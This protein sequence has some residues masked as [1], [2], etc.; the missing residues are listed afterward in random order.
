MLGQDCNG[1]QGAVP[2]PH[3]GTKGTCLGPRAS[4]GPAGSSDGVKRGGKSAKKE[5]LEEEKMM[6]R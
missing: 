5:K 6:G 2:D 3:R 1:E 4:G